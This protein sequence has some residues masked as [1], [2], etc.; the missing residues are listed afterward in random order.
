MSQWRRIGWP[1]EVY[2]L[3]KTFLTVSI[4]WDYFPP[5][6]RDCNAIC[7]WLRLQ[8]YIHRQSRKQPTEGDHRPNPFLSQIRG[9]HLHCRRQESRELHEVPKIFNLSHTY[10]PYRGTSQ[11]YHT[12]TDPKGFVAERDRQYCHVARDNL[13]SCSIPRSLANQGWRTSSTRG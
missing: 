2:C 8:W 1:W 9:L 13:F 11:S 5:N 10:L 4:Q 3:H 7:A 12:N 6:G